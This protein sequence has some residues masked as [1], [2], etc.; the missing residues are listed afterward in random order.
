MG[1]LSASLIQS[2]MVHVRSC[3]GDIIRLLSFWIQTASHTPGC[4]RRDET[5]FYIVKY[6]YYHHI[7]DGRNNKI[8]IIRIQDSGSWCTKKL[9]ATIK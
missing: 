6:M 4:V 2:L 8:T 5:W 9:A 3:V 7:H 1:Q